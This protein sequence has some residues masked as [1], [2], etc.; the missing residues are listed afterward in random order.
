MMSEYTTFLGSDD[1]LGVFAFGLDRVLPGWVRADFDWPVLDLGPGSKEI[2]G[3]FRMDWP[4]YNFEAFAFSGNILPQ[5][6]ATVGGVFAI[7]VLEHL[8]DPRPL[9]ADV[10]RVLRPGCP[11]TIFVPHARS[12]MYLQDLDHKTPFILDTW[13]NH[14]EPHPYY[15][16]GRDDVKGLFEVGFNSL[17]GIKEE[18]VCILTQLIRTEEPWSWI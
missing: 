18:N 17:F 5:D 14:V 9:I 15:T 6:D 7:N 3:A 13:K 2:P 10:A 16:K 11:F 8:L 4:E 1:P 12:G